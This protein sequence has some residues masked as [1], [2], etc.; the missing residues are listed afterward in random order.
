MLCTSMKFFFILRRTE[1]GIITNVHIG[2]RVKYSLFYILMQREF[3][4]QIFY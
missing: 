1:S 3:Y 2:L 4:G